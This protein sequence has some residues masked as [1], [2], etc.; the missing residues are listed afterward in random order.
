LRLE[1]GTPE[2]QNSLLPGMSPTMTAGVR[3]AAA[4][5]RH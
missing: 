4:G 5:E 2:G 3:L 1:R